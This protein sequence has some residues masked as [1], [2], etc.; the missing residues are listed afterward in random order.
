MYFT[1]KWL[2]S[3]NAYT[4]TVLLFLL[5]IWNERKWNVYLAVRE[6]MADF[7]SFRASWRWPIWME[8]DLIK[9][10]NSEVIT[11]RSWRGRMNGQTLKHY[12]NTKKICWPPPFLSIVYVSSRRGD[13]AI[14]VLNYGSALWLYWAMHRL[15]CWSVP[16]PPSACLWFPSGSRT[17]RQKK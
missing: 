7:L 4:Q 5:W 9:Q 6:L 11:P 16:F 14:H 12:K 1:D 10:R 2:R 3:H 17:E 15:T 8:V 13:C